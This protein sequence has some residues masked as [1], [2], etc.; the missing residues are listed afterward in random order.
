MSTNSKTSLEYRAHTFIIKEPKN[1]VNM[2]YK[3]REANR[4]WTKTVKQ[5]TDLYCKP[6][7]CS[8]VCWCKKEKQFSLNFK[9]TIR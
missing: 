3:Q 5:L 4:F 1:N 7:Y 6:S 9:V 2:K 8:L